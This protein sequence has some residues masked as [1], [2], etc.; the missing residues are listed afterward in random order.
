M[1]DSEVRTLRGQVAKFLESLSETQSKL[2]ADQKLEMT[3]LEGSLKTALKKLDYMLENVE[4]EG[5]PNGGNTYHR[6]FGNPIFHNTN[7]FITTNT[8]NTNPF[9]T[10][11]RGRYMIQGGE[12][13][14]R[15]TIE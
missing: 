1:Q 8:D 4:L 9:L 11:A 12:Q 15:F 5:L 14:E 13:F 6:P 10:A 3:V 2:N 7:T